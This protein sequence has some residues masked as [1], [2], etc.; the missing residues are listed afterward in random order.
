MLSTEI[1]DTLS[2][3]ALATS[4]SANVDTYRNFCFRDGQVATFNGEFGLLAKSPISA[5]GCISA[6]KLLTVLKRL[7]GEVV[8]KDTGKALAISCGSFKSSIGTAGAA[9]FPRI[10]PSEFSP[11]EKSSCLFPALNKVAFC[12]GDSEKILNVHGIGVRENKVYASDSKRAARYEIDAIY[13]DPFVLPSKAIKIAKKIG[14]PDEFFRSENV[15]IFAYSSKS[16]V[17]VSCLEAKK[18]PFEA[19]D[20]IFDALIDPSYCAEFPEELSAMIK[21]VSSVSK[22]GSILFGS[23]REN[24]LVS[25]DEKEFGDASEMIDWNCPH[26]FSVYINSDYLV[27]ALSHTRKVDLYDVV[28][29]KKRFLRFFEDRFQHII[30]LME[31]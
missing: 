17:L 28:C 19:C 24:L 8:I 14:E 27:E 5:T 16:M 4:T 30:A 7:S 21:R 12:C 13:P 20:D 3:V 22:R 1:L 10:L 25:C 23:D 26:E 6:E 18:F 11:L 15:L 29:G 9:F 31:L 2:I